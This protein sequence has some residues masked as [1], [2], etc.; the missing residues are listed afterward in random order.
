MF[1]IGLDDTFI[2]SSCY[3]RT[4]RSKPTTQRIHDAIEDCG[5]SITL[6]TITSTAAFGLGCIST[7]P[8]I[9]WLCL[10]AFPTVAIIYIYQLTFFVA[11]VTL[12]DRRI[13]AKRRDCCVW[14]YTVQ[15]SG[16][17]GTDRERAGRAVVPVE[18]AANASAEE[19]ERTS[20]H[21]MGRYAEFLLQPW[22][23]VTVL[24]GFAALAIACGFSVSNLTQE[25]D[26]KDMLPSDSYVTDFMEVTEDYTEMSGIAPGV[27]FRFVDQSDEQIQMQ[28]DQYIRDLVEID[29]IVEPPYFF[30]LN[31]FRSFVNVSSVTDLSFNEQLD[32]FLSNPVF[33]DLHA[34]N[35]VRD[36]SGSIITSRCFIDMNNIEWDDVKAQIDALED[37]RGVTKA[38]EI[39]RGRDEWA[40]FVSTCLHVHMFACS[41]ANMFA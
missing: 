28:M 9:F 40:F 25:F 38:Q 26:V 29:A 27:Y 31:D 19:E 22:V 1:G 30:W 34:D 41:H 32:L 18:D 37:Q 3:E 12:D 36:K 4:D 6:T 15:E 39:N 16:E 21:I 14:V 33:H 2:I 7:I 10:Y 8:A 5:F 13:H 17:E 24:A 11:C 20:E 23:K 35:I